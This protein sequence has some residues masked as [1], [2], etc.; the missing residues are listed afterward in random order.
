MSW[1]LEVAV[2]SLSCVVVVTGSRCVVSQLCCRGYWKVA[3]LSLSCVVV[4]GSCCVVSQLC[5][6]GYWKL[7]CCLSVVL[8]WLL[9]VAVLS[10]SCVVVV[11]VSC[12]VVSQ[13]CCRGYCKLLCCLSVVL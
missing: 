8:S 1:L 2:L 7:L 12:C 9:E 11:T 10:L 13:L 5:C 4:T 6:R 3:V